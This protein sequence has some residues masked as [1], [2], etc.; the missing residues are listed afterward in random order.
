MYLK[1]YFKPHLPYKMNDYW[2]CVCNINY[3]T[4]HF[5]QVPG[6]CQLFLSLVRRNLLEEFITLKP[7]F[8]KLGELCQERG[9]TNT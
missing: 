3:L 9:A 4:L 1:V 8:I 6:T 7:V 2:M 5:F